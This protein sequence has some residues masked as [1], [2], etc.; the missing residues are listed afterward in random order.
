MDQTWSKSIGDRG[1][2]KNVFTRL[3]QR[4]GRQANKTAMSFANQ[5]FS[6]ANNHGGNVMRIKH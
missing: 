5:D 2:G 4:N 6:E 3:A 1:G